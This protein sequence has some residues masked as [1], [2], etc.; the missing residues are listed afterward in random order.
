MSQLFL[1]GIVVSQ[2]VVVDISVTRQRDSDPVGGTLV[3]IGQCVF[4]QLPAR[5]SR[6]FQGVA[7]TAVINRK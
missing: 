1:H 5:W 2:S 4:T 7:K 6:S 3:Q